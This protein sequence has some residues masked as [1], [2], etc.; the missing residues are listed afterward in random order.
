MEELPGFEKA[1]DDDVNKKNYHGKLKAL[2]RF[3]PCED[4][5]LL[6]GPSDRG[7][8]ES[9]V[10]RTWVRILSDVLEEQIQDICAS[11]SA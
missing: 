8:Y 3:T 11:L 1:F 7:V 4:W 2:G 9:L 6:S 10:Q 5:F